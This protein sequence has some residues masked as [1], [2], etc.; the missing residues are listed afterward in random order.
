MGFEWLTDLQ[1]NDVTGDGA[2]GG[3]Q[4]SAS[5]YLAQTT[6]QQ[7]RQLSLYHRNFSGQSWE[8]VDRLCFDGL[9]S[10]ARVTADRGASS[11]EANFCTFHRVLSDI[12]VQGCWFELPPNG[13]LHAHQIANLSLAKIVL[14]LLQ[15]HVTFSDFVALDTSLVD[16]A[17]STTV[18]PYIVRENGSMWQ[19]LQKV[20][21]DEFYVIYFNRSNQVVYKCHPQFAGVPPVSVITLDDTMLLAP[22]QV[23]YRTG[24]KARNVVV[25]GITDAMET[26]ESGYPSG[27]GVDVT[28]PPFEIRCNTQVRLNEL[29]VRQY[30]WLNRDYVVTLLLPGA[31]DFELYDH[32]KL[33]LVGVAETNKLPFDWDAKSFW[34][35]RVTYRRQQQY[36]FVTEL[37]LDEGYVAP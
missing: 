35:N 33:T 30:R 1:L 20:A 10:P 24:R 7:N 15:H 8:G 11:V 9:M 5:F 17:G 25:L 18:N 32:V 27:P 14:H 12:P 3:Y 21:S 6:V 19:A 31:W 2:S 16:V 26:L 23:E 34:V 29:A 13:A 22:Y 37:V 4:G 28:G 36:G